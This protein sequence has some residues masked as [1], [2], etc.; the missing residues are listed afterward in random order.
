VPTKAR[1]VTEKANTLNKDIAK[2]WC[3]AAPQLRLA[4]QALAVHWD[5]V[6]QSAVTEIAIATDEI[7]ILTATTMDKNR[8]QN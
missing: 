4:G 6:S 2:F 7:Q 8:K 3:A 1:S 5:P